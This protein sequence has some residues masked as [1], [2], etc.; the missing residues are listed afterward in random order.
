[1]TYML[2]AANVVVYLVLLPAGFQPPA[3]DDPSL[4]DYLQMIAKESGGAR[5]ELMQLAQQ[6]SAYDLIVYRHGFKP[7]QPSLF[8][9]FTSMFLHGGLL[10]LVGNMLFLWIYGDNVEH[11]L[12]RWR[13]LLAYLGTGVI[14]AL[15]D[16]ILRMGSGIPSVGASGAISGLLGLYFIWFPRNRVRVWVF[17]FPFFANVVELPARLVLG[18]YLLF[19]NLVPLLLTAGRGGVSHGAH[20]GGFIAGAAIA[21]GGERLFAFR[22]EAD[23]RRGPPGVPPVV[24]ADAAE[25]FRQAMQE[26]RWDLAAELYFTAPHSLT[27]KMLGPWEKIALGHQLERHDHPKAALAAYQRALVDHPTGPG[28]AAAH[29]GAARVMM[30]AMRNP[31]GAYQHL[32]AALEE[33]PSAEERS[34]ARALMDDLAR[35]VRS[36]PRHTPS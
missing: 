18:F 22:P 29:L 31:T 15:G 9:M 26:G 10:H 33:D 6:M 13:F 2:I 28:R 24:R 32:Y 7:A 20:I 27:R 11:R 34:Q 5:D 12:G 4:S 30:G 25:R 8:D 21:F 36:V 16:G 3:V 35:L 17:L 14:A 1:M 19:D 23:V